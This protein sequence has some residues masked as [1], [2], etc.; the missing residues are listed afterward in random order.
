[1]FCYSY[2][3]QE[4]TQELDKDEKHG[5]ELHLKYVC[6]CVFLIAAV[7]HFLLNLLKL[8]FSNCRWPREK[9]P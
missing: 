4:P 1:M 9:D 6:V 5:T 2:L 7:P 3:L 8:L